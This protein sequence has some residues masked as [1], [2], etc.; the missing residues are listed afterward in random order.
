MAVSVAVAVAVALGVSVA[1]AV[2]VAVGVGVAVAVSV[3]V[4]LA[5]GVSVAVAVTVEVAVTVGVSVAVAVAVRVSDAVAVG[6][7]VAVAVSVAVGLPLAVAVAVSVAVADSVAVAVGV[8]PVAVAVGV[9]L[10]L[11]VG[12]EPIPSGSSKRSTRL[13][14][15]SATYRL[16]IGSIATPAGWHS[17][18]ALGAGSPGKPSAHAL[19]MKSVP[20]APWPKARSAVTSPAP[21]AILGAAS[22][23]LY[24]NTRLLDASET[25]RSPFASRLTPAGVQSPMAVALSHPPV[26]K[27]VPLPPCPKT[28]SAV[29]SPA[30][31]IALIAPSGWLNSST[32]E[33]PMSATNRSP[34]ESETSPLGVHSVLAL[35]APPPLHDPAVKIPPCPN[36]VSAIESPAPV[37]MLG[38]ASG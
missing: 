36:T 10:A 8:A 31:V 22:G 29:V 12:V 25:N 17:P 21:V 27:V 16:P 9:A 2:E 32:R 6:E 3:A 13:L 1:V 15:P 18:V 11:G 37:I 30:P 5:V 38:A 19:S 20:D 4:P 28:R 7:S 24:S 35:V 23:W 34:F 14:L 26:V 33:L